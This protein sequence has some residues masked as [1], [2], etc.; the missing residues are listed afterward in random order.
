MSTTITAGHQTITD[1]TRGI[2]AAIELKNVNKNYKFHGDTVCALQ[3]INLAISEREFVAITGPSGSGKSTLLQIV[4]GLERPSSGKV[5]VTSKNIATYHDGALAAF[6]GKEIGFVF[7]SFYLQP[8]LTVE[9]NIQL[10]GIFAHIRPKDRADRVRSLLQQIGLEGYDKHLPRQLSGGQ[11]QRVAIARA[12]FHPPKILLADEPTG[13]LDQEN[14]THIVRL[15]QT[16]RAEFGITVIIVTHNNEI[17]Q[18]A[19]REI[20]LNNGRLL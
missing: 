17:A 6:R 4:G 3:D 1:N 7:Q 2:S 11:I 15:F 13:N 12:L 8:F 9:Q 20:K 14:S 10:P 5:F 16:I 18:I 19:D